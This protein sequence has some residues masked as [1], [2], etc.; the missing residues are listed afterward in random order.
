MENKMRVALRP[1]I[2]LMRVNHYIKNLFMLPGVALALTFEYQSN[3]RVITYDILF[4]II[5]TFTALCL[6]SSAN[7]IINEWLD[8]NFDQKHPMKKHRVASWYQFHARNVYS[9]YVVVVI[10]AGIITY[11]LNSAIQL[12][13]SG[14]LF[15]GILYNVK[16]F[17]LKD[18]HYLDVISES[19]NNPIR[20][21]IGWHCLQPDKVIPVSAFISY[22]GVGIFLMSLKRYSEM[23][24]V[25]DKE[26][27]VSYRVAFARWTPDKLMTFSSVGS[28]IAAFFGGILLVRHR[29][30]YILMFPVL[31]IIFVQYLSMSLRLDP[32]SYAPEKLMRQRKF[33]YSTLLIIGV[34]ILTTFFDI[35]LLHQI[36]GT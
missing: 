4:N 1:Y 16:P 24:I 22:W 32:A 11:Q 5:L 10:A 26:L 29:L 31:A 21:A 2:S 13:L 30:E 18:R 23:K 27:L 3:Y 20:L 36:V 19:V 34:F 25:D 12:Y 7:Y 33:A 6:V 9:F 15:M 17:R 28:T 35:P 8:R 14:L